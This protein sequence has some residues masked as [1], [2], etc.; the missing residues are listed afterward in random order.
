MNQLKY[1][2]LIV[3]G[4]VAMN[5]CK[6]DDEKKG[7]PIVEPKTE[8]G[9]AMFG[10][11]IT[12]TAHVSDNEV[13]LSTLKAQIFFSE[14]MVAETV[15]RTK[16]EGDYSGKIFVPYYANIPN[17]SATFRYVLQNINFTIDTKESALPLTRPDFPY[18]TLHLADGTEL[19][20]DRTA[21]YQYSITQDFPKD[22]EGYIVA[23]KV[24]DRGN[25]ITFGWSNGAITQG[26]TNTIKFKNAVPGTYSITFNTFNYEGS[27]FF[28][29]LF[30][31]EPMEPV[32][33]ESYA[34]MGGFTTNQVIP[35]S[36]IV[37]DEWD[38]GG[39]FTKKSDNELTFGLPDGK[40]KITA[41]FVTKVFSYVEVLPI[42][43][44]LSSGPFEGELVEE[45][46]VTFTGVAADWWIDPDFFI[47]EDDHYLFNAFSGKYRITA[48]ATLKYLIVEAMSGNDLASLQENGTGAIWIIGTNI[49]KPNVTD[50]EVGWNTDKALCMAPIGGKKYRIT[51]IGGTSISTDEINFKFF[52]QKGWGGEF[53]SDNITTTSSLIFV[54]N[55]SNGRDSGNLGI[56][57]GKTLA[58]GT[59]YVLTVDLSAGNSSAVLTV[60]EQ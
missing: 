35:V 18:L 4:V 59:T 2:L 22:V 57:D 43:I 34:T 21:L 49:G 58:E 5:S 46:E 60:T 31:G 3:F 32:D 26:V 19:R 16:T 27:P 37:I 56:V 12:F 24:G 42:N 23:P 51:V 33:D 17:A 8:L 7:N 53:S 14:E 25:E 40:Y 1:F 38:L 55:G 28:E 15:I 44:D 13:P 30:N 50:N 39:I 9:A 29:F 36:G 47:A 54:G 52:H 10:D 45:Q 48:D 11:S 41:N 6:D 20:M